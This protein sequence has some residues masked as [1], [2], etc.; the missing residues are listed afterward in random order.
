MV[1]EDSCNLKKVLDNLYSSCVHSSSAICIGIDG[2]TG[3]L[4]Q[5]G[6]Q[7]IHGGLRGM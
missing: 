5:V 3:A 6:S 1:K 4:P 2:P 7:S